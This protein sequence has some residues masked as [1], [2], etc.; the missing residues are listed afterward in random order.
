MPRFRIEEAAAIVT[1][2]L[3]DEADDEIIQCA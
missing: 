1:S 2:W 3:I